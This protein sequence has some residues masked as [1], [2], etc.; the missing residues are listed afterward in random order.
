MMAT[1]FGLSN[2][3]KLWPILAAFAFLGLS[4]C[5]D[6]APRNECAEI[7]CETPEAYC[8]GE[9]AVS[10]SGGGTCIKSTGVCDIEAVERRLRSEEHTSELQSRPHL[11]CRLL[12]EKKKT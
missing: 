5:G 6:S 4:A 9:T 1:L 2:S 8:D 7:T 12:L 10:Y 11:V 3:R